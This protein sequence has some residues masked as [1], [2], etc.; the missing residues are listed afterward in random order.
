MWNGLLAGTVYTINIDRI[1]LDFQVLGGLNVAYLPQQKLIYENPANNWF[2]LDRNT[3]TTS[4][5]YGLLAGTALRFPVTDRL[6]LRAGIDYYRS[7]ASTPYEQL[8]V[9]KQGAT[10]VTEKLGNGSALVPIEMFSGSIGFVYYL[11]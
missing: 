6:N 8:R 7:R 5:S 9:S 11:N 3:S 10:V 4:F 1:F 2:Y